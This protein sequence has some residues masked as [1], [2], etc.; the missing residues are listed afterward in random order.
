MEPAGE[1]AKLGW[2]QLARAWAKTFGYQPLNLRKQ[3]KSSNKGITQDSCTENQLQRSLGW[4]CL[5]WPRVV[6]LGRVL[7]RL[8]RDRPPT[9][10]LCWLLHSFQSVYLPS[11]CSPFLIAAFCSHPSLTASCHSGRCHH[12]CTSFVALTWPLPSGPFTEQG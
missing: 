9:H 5:S 8:C 12:F 10:T 1:T 7:R 2:G 6:S 11:T 4:M 3:L